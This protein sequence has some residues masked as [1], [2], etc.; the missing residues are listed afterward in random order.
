M[1][2]C[3]LIQHSG[4]PVACPNPHWWEDAWWEQPAADEH[5]PARRGT[6]RV[7]YLRFGDR[8]K[9]GTS[10]SFKGRLST[11]PYHEVLAIEPGTFAL[12]RE[13]HREFDALRIQGQREWFHDAP[14]LG[15]HAGRL[16]IKHGPPETLMGAA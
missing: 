1:A 9:I 3:T 11:L 12:E 10:S 5:I 14:A 6:E 15:A 2:T 16:R 8:I 4:F 7:Y 13:R